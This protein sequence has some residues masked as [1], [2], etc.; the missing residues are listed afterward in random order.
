MMN[1]FLYPSLGEK[2][3]GPPLSRKENKPGKNFSPLGPSTFCL[4]LKS[5]GISLIIL[6]QILSK[7][8][9][10]IKSCN[11]NT[12]LKFYKKRKSPFSLPSRTKIGFFKSNR[13]CLFLTGGKGFLYV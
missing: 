1:V 13:Y 4:S 8:I 12:L 9:R 3:K 2:R 5:I 10:M 11:F 6:K 7:K